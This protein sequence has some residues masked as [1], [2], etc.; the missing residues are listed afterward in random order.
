MNN[1][2]L[3]DVAIVVL[4]VLELYV[5]C[6]EWLGLDFPLGTDGLSEL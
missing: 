6:Y 4:C 1:S 3:C 5:H 2:F